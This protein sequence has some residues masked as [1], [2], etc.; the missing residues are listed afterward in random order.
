MAAQLIY[1]KTLQTHKNEKS[2]LK[3]QKWHTSYSSTDAANECQ[4]SPLTELSDSF[5]DSTSY[6]PL[7]IS[8]SKCI[9]RRDTLDVFQSTVSKHWRT[10]WIRRL[11]VMLTAHSCCCWWWWWWWWEVRWGWL[12]VCCCSHCWHLTLSVWNCRVV[13]ALLTGW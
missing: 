11:V 8:G 12:C 7:W 5:G 6:N 10:Q 13:P 9:S 4:I 3:R 2:K 1:I